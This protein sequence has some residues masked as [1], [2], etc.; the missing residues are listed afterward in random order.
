MASKKTPITKLDSAIMKILNEYGD[1]VKNNTIKI[2]KDMLKKGAAAVRESARSVVGGSGKYASGWTSE[3]EVKRYGV[4]GSIYNKSAYQLAH[5]IEYGHQKQNGGREPAR[6]HIAP[7]EEKL[8]KEY[9]EGVIN[10][11]KSD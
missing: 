8:V 4:Y 2:T 1:D 6:P 5:L 9:E 3:V 7:V 10:A 11:I